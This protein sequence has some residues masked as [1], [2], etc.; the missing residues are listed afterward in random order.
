[1]PN[2]GAYVFSPH[3]MQAA[4]QLADIVALVAANAQLYEDAQATI[5]ATLTEL[6]PLVGPQ[7]AARGRRMSVV[8]LGDLAVDMAN[9]RAT[10]DNR[11]VN[12]T[13]TEF[14]LL[15]VLIE[16][17][18]HVVDPETLLRRVWG[19]NY[20]GRSTVVDVGVH[21]LRRKIEDGGG[22]PRRIVTVRGSGYMLVPG[23]TLAR[24]GET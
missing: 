3:D 9:K 21:R 8:E 18:G 5:S 6:R 12:L 14:D 22:T 24:Q 19:A 23:S 13:P 4:Q 16:N 1:M 11:P 20:G 17:S 7:Q 10:I 15:A 2:A